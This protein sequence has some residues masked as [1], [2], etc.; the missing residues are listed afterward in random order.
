MV[1][2]LLVSAGTHH[3]SSLNKLPGAHLEQCIDHS[4]LHSTELDNFFE[5]Q[6]VKNSFDHLQVVQERDT[7]PLCP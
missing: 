4:K 7:N 6:L 1:D 5:H 3:G 2:N